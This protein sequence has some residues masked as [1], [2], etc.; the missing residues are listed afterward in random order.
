MPRNSPAPDV[1]LHHVVEQH[2]LPV[3]WRRRVA[4]LVVLSAE[5]HRMVDYSSERTFDPGNC[6]TPLGT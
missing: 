5:R 2:D 6:H 1:A 3:P 4:A